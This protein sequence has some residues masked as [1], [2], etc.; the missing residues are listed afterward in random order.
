V[1]GAVK[2]MAWAKR[3]AASVMVGLLAGAGGL[4]AAEVTVPTDGTH[5]VSTPSPASTQ[6]TVTG[7]P[8]TF[9]VEPIA[10]IS[11]AGKVLECIGVVPSADGKGLL[12][13]VAQ[14]DPEQGLEA[15]QV[16]AVDAAGKTTQL[17]QTPVPKGQRP[18][19]FAPGELSS[20]VVNSHGELFLAGRF[21]VGYST[22]RKVGMNG[23]VLR[24]VPYTD[25]ATAKMVSPVIRGMVM[26]GDD[27]FLTI[28]QDTILYG[29]DLKEKWRLPESYNAALAGL[30]DSERKQFVVAYMGEKITDKLTDGWHVRMRAIDGKGRL[31]K[32][33]TLPGL[34]IRLAMA[35]GDY[36]LF[37]DIARPMDRESM[38]KPDRF[39]L[40]RLN[41]DLKELDSR[42]LAEMPVP[43]ASLIFPLRLAARA[44]GNI[45]AI[46][47]GRGSLFV[48]EW[49]PTGKLVRKQDTLWR[50]AIARPLWLDLNS[51]DARIV[52]GEIGPGHPGKES[53]AIRVDYLRVR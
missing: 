20:M 37:R 24:E 5:A 16:Y 22:I 6:S 2:I 4:A 9:A 50:T 12:I 26:N 7:L 34:A 42:A 10:R 21:T 13:A 36:L 18:F 51:G 3:R 23:E 39:V 44:N 30:Y 8:A 27:E 15:Y 40:T 47:N 11:E 33:A 48:G 28:A 17:F 32:E 38:E 31:V 41:G 46:G 14:S 53:A 1:E 43:M 52:S 45:V 29:R 35:G 19:G 49:D 25:E